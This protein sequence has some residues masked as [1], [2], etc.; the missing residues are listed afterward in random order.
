M[1]K[2]AVQPWHSPEHSSGS[3]SHHLQTKWSIRQG[4]MQEVGKD[5]RKQPQFYT[6]SYKP[7]NYEFHL[8]KSTN[9]L[10][11][12][13][14]KFLRKHI[15]FNGLKTATSEL[16]TR[17]YTIDIFILEPNN[18]NDVWDFSSLEN[19]INWLLPT[20]ILESVYKVL[21]SVSLLLSGDLK[22]LIRDCQMQGNEMST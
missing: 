12:S 5:R 3:L 6:T 8:Y 17:K 16:C 21:P 14:P 2:A 15:Y 4:E 19:F 13:E 7:H 10:F 20:I 22:I 18:R 9:Q 11:T 1:W